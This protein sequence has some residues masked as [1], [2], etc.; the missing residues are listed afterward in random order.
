MANVG[1]TRHNYFPTA[2]MA[3][4]YKLGGSKQP[5]SQGSRGLEAEAKMLAGR[6][7][8]G[9][10]QG[11][12]HSLGKKYSSFWSLLVYL[13]FLGLNLHQY[14][15]YLCLY[16]DFSCVPVHFCLFPSSYIKASC[17]GFRAK[18]NSVSCH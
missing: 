2:I 3:K 9:R 1:H 17:V 4:Y 13:V 14:S 10:L 12:T 18:P 16:T 7:S 8:L 6:C 15:L 5:F 11:R